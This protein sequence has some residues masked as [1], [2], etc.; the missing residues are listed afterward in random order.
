MIDDV[1]YL[2][3]LLNVLLLFLTNTIIF[4]SYY[5]HTSAFYRMH[6]FFMI[7]MNPDQFIHMILGLA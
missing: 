6:Y 3:S 7:S 2:I 4:Y 1:Y 5:G